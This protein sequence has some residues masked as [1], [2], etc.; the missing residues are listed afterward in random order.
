MAIGAV[1][2]VLVLI[3][4]FGLNNV[5]EGF[6]IAAPLAA[7]SQ[8]PSWR[9]LGLVGLVGGGPTLLGTVIATASSRPTPSCFS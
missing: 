2:V 8:L 5:T 9:F 6:G 7:D 3:I 1:A 4:G